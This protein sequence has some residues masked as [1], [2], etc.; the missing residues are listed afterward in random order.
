MVGNVFLENK[1]V[2]GEK[3]WNVGYSANVSIFQLGQIFFL[4]T[5]SCSVSSTSVKTGLGMWP[6]EGRIL[7]YFTNLEAF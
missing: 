5:E 2:A 3:K 1:S 4:A 6:Q 7:E